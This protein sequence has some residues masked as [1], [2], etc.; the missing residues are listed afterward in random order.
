MVTK[1]G[2]IILL[3]GL[4][5]TVA[6]AGLWVRYYFAIQKANKASIELACKENIEQQFEGRLADIDRFEYDNLMHTHF[7]NLHIK[8]RDSS[9]HYIDYQ[10]LLEPNKEILDFAQPG[11][12][13]IKV[14]GKDTFTLMD[15]TGNKRIFKISKCAGYE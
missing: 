12:W 6:N 8:I 14:K 9:N 5:W 2:E 1:A 3:I 7:F 10:Y 4:L 15:T 13:A 11:Q